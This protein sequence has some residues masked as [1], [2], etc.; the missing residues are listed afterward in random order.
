M[1][2]FHSCHRNGQN[3]YAEEG[4]YTS[5]ESKYKVDG[6]GGGRGGGEKENRNKEQ[7]E[8]SI[9]NKDADDNSKEKEELIYVKGRE[10][11]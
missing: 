3:V 5:Y 1:Q 4:T 8:G 6:G 10:K 11:I 7:M 9:G 2:Y